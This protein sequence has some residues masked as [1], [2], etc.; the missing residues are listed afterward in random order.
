MNRTLNGGG[1]PDARPAPPADVWRRRPITWGRMP[2][3]AFVAGPLPGTEPEP[4]AEPAIAPPPPAAEPPRVVEPPPLA[5][6]PTAETPPRVA[7]RRRS[8][9]PLFA[10]VA[11]AALAVAAVAAGLWLRREPPV[12]PAAAVQS[13]ASDAVTVAPPAKA[14]SAA[15]STPEPV[16]VETPAPAPAPAPAPVRAPAR[17]PVRV[18]AAAPVVTDAEFAPPTPEPVV[19]APAEIDLTPTAPPITPWTPPPAADPSAPLVTAPPEPG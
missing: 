6:A 18:E 9:A 13:P 2:Q 16:Q 8:R 1:A 19:L 14:P 11:A 7:R 5:K 10:G 17:A 15:G 4:P 3:A 12:Q